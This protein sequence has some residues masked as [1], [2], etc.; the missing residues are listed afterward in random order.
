MGRYTTVRMPETIQQRPD[1]ERH[2]TAPNEMRRRQSNRSNITN[3][4][5]MTH[6]TSDPFQR[7]EKKQE[8]TVD[9]DNEYFALNPWYNQQKSKPV[10]GLAA[11][12][13][14]SV[15]KGMWW[16]RGDLRKSLYKVDEDKD[17]DGI[18]RNDQLEHISERGG[19]LESHMPLLPA[20]S[21]H[22]ARIRRKLHSI[23][24]PSRQRTPA[25]RASTR[26]TTHHSERAY[27]QRPASPHK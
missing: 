4:T 24:H 2:N 11:P 3:A 10:Y 17:K 7:S 13:P 6:R 19:R 9:I 12:L 5:N 20:Y 26:P 21:N 18:D 27:R 23:L 25:Q 8:Q 1:N 22:Q 15:R 16:G 14:H